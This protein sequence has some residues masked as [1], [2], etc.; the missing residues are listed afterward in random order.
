MDRSG[1]LDHQPAHAD[2]PAVDLDPV[3]FGDLFGQ[4]FHADLVVPAGS[5]VKET[6]SF[7]V[8]LN[9]VFT[10]VVNH[11]VTV[12]VTVRCDSPDANWKR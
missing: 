9:P 4:G 6:V 8:G 10:R 7:N 3:K 12:V 5:R 11:C 1:H 2:H